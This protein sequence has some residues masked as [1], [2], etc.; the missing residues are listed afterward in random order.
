MQSKTPMIIATQQLYAL[1]AML[2]DD[3][4]IEQRAAVGALAAQVEIARRLEGI[5]KSLD[6]GISVRTD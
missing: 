1:D 5:E 3:S 6:L 4:T 2:G